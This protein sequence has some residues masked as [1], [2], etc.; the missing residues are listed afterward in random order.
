MTQESRQGTMR[1]TG[2]I[3]I[4]FYTYICIFIPTQKNYKVLQEHCRLHNNDMKYCQ[5]YWSL[6][7]VRRSWA[8]ATSD[9]IALCPNSEV[10]ASMI[11]CPI[12]S[13][14]YLISSTG[15]SLMDTKWSEA[16]DPSVCVLCLIVRMTPPLLQQ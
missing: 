6:Y 16:S 12:D 3:F 1:V 14:I 4:H 15:L 10:L 8:W 2:S 5:I 9:G 11:H 13:N 7:H